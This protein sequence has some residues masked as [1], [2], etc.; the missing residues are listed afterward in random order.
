MDLIKWWKNTLTAY[1]NIPYR[2]MPTVP[3][4]TVFTFSFDPYSFTDGWDVLSWS[5]T[6]TYSFLMD[7][8]VNKFYN[9][10]TQYLW[11]TLFSNNLIYKI[12]N[13]N[14]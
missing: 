13:T 7:L 11:V 4:P 14:M 2:E 3:T 6:T 9:L 12:W 1:L 10:M 5:W 8:W